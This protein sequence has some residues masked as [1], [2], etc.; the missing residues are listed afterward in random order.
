[1]SGGTLPMKTITPVSIWY[2]G[3]VVNATQLK[4]YSIYNDLETEADFYYELLMDDD[5]PVQRGN[6]KMTGTTYAS[7]NGNTYAWNWAATQLG[8]TII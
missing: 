5:V 8:L 7:Y 4:L 2:N 6:L 3:S 1:V